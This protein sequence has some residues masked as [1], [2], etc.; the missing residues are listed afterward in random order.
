MTA[1]QRPS[2]PSSSIAEVGPRAAV[3]RTRWQART[4]ETS[5]STEVSAIV[6]K[7]RARRGS[8]R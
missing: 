5:I 6:A 1:T 2:P 4:P 8:G 3:E 7:I